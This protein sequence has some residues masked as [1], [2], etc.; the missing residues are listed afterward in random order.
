M[1][2]PRHPLPRW[3]M[4]PPTPV[5]RHIR[6]R[7][8]RRAFLAFLA[9]A[10]LAMFVYWRYLADVPRDY[11]RVEDQFKYGSIGSEQGNGVPYWIWK[12]L[13][14]MFPEHL[15]RNGL[16]G[17]EAL[18]FVVERDAEGRP[19]HDTPVGFSRRR[20]VGRVELVGLN[21]ASC[22][23]S[24][25][26]G[27]ESE[28]PR[29]T[30]GMPAHRLDLLSYFGFLI[31][32]ARD[33]RFTTDNLMAAIDRRASLDPI[34][35]LAYRSV[36]IPRTRERLLAVGG[37]AERL[38][39]HPS[40]V[41]RIDTF[42][43]YK[44]IQF[45]YRDPEKLR[46]GNTDLPSIWNQKIRGGMQLHWDGNNTSV[47]ERNISAGIG[48][49]ASPTSIDLAR[50][51]RIEAWL[52]TL[53]P[54]KWPEGW[55]FDAGL[56]ER[57]APIYRRYCAD[58]HG[59]PEEDFQGRRVGTVVPIGEIGT[60]PER[61][62][63]Y[64]VDFMNNQYSLGVDQ[65]WRFHA[66]RKTGGYANQP[67]DGIWARA[68]YLHNGSVPTLRHLLSPAAERP[69]RFHV[70]D[71]VYDQDALGFSWERAGR[72]GV[73]FPEFDATRLGDSNAGH[74]GPAYGTD[75]PEAD[76]AALLEYLKTL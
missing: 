67:L 25:Y 70:G 13:P 49:G 41:G 60:D 55:K 61:L 73:T 6:D 65:D 37:R 12:V 28:E 2:L 1:P 14:E 27:S 54:P 36:A 32:C 10:A 72:G 18:G 17:Y 9:V 62:K 23:V 4:D 11:T 71:D 16:S 50:L 66:F 38:F 15:P 42:T 51:A 53:P 52:W 56:A 47:H 19:L 33:P 45:G 35:R 57:G 48:A 75:L 68:P 30:L 3:E 31:R 22:H 8:R 46:P 44:L 43:P 5:E 26:R 40:G 20:T 64:T 21:C 58:C 24:V 59:L 7:R 34:E 74:E 69:G 63:S 76:K 39:E 29:V